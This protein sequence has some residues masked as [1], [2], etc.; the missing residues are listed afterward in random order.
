MEK[1]FV[2]GIVLWVMFVL[3]SQVADADPTSVTI[4]HGSNLNG[5]MSPCPT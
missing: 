3:F 1:H 2:A 4:I 5:N